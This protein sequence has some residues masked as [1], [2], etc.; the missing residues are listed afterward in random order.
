MGTYG[1]AT[2]KYFRENLDGDETTNINF[3]PANLSPSTVAL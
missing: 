1:Q 2:W 3:S